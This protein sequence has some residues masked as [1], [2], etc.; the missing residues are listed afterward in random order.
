MGAALGV[1]E[2]S[3]LLC[4][5]V[6]TVSDDVGEYLIQRVQEGDWAE[7]GN[8]YHSASFECGR[9]PGLGLSCEEMLG[10]ND[11]C[12]QSGKIEG[13]ELFLFWVL[14]DLEE[15]VRDS[16]GSWCSPLFQSPQGDQQNTPARG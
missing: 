4:V 15:F 12:E 7:V 9:D 13:P 5:A 16:V 1:H 11:R 2:D 6:D 8:V 3:N 10:S 14:S